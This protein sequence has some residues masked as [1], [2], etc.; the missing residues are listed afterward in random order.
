MCQG[1]YVQ[2]KMKFLMF[3]PVAKRTVHRHDAND[4]VDVP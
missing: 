1:A 3:N 4:N 2:L